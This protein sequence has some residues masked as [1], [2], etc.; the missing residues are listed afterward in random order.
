MCGIVGIGDFSGIPVD[1]SVIFSMT[2][3]LEHRGPDGFDT[4]NFENFG[5][6][7]Q[8]L[9]IL[10]QSNAAL[11]PMLSQCGNY[12]LTYN[13]EI[14][15]Y[16][17]LKLRL[18]NKGYVFKSTGDSEV[19]LYALIEW[20]PKTLDML[21]GM[22]AFGF[23]NKKEKTLF[24]ARDRYGIKPLYYSFFNNKFIFASEIK[25]VLKHPSFEKKLNETILEEYFT[26]QNILT[27]NTFYE[28]VKILKPGHFLKVD[29]YSSKIRQEQYWD[30]EFQNSEDTE[31]SIDK[32]SEELSFL[33]EQAVDRQMVSDVEIG[34]YLS[35][36]ID[37]GAISLLANRGEPDLKTFTCGFDLSNVSGFEQGM[38]ERQAAERI[39]STIRSEHYEVVIKSGDMERAL[40]DVVNALEDP[41]VGQSYP[42]YYIA[43]LASKFV[44][45]CLSGIGGDELFG[46]YPWRYFS[47]DEFLSQ[48]EF[49]SQYYN[50]WQR[51][52]SC[53]ERTTFFKPMRTKTQPINTFEIFKNVLPSNGSKKLSKNEM[54][55]MCFYFEA[56]TFLHSLLVV[57][58]KLS[59][60]HSLETRV[61]FLDN[62]L[63]DFSL[64]CPVSMKIR[65]PFTPNRVDENII[66]EKKNQRRNINNHGKYILRQSIKNKMPKDLADGRKKGFSAPDATWFKSQ[67]LQF[68]NDKLDNPNAFIYDFF[69]RNTVSSMLE[70]H[71]SGAENKRLLIWSLLSF[72][73]LLQNF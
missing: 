58:D 51:L 13:G 1:P 31:K 48:N 53:E 71:L 38:D 73:E 60:F 14:Y 19:L 61:P 3:S 70:R 25:A 32:K 65:H 57:E 17:E 22:F 23:F 29:F 67:S 11:Q 54:L 2:K 64:Q 43:K 63:V 52:I 59:M 30:F 69:D 6:G 16:R 55:N 8:R 37:S 42:N 45:V 27:D 9:S 49:A 24:I 34:S 26:F 46:G 41:R 40:P 47:N 56:K 68:V 50:Q 62:D 36:G 20:G 4:W 21:N 72:E 35:G 66:L 15:N 33:I 28:N 44:K 39:S 7:H 18:E 5:F 12:V 10:D